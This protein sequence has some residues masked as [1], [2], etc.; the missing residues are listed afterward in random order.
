MLIQW[1]LENDKWKINYYGVQ[2]LP[3][4]H[5]PGGLQEHSIFKEVCHFSI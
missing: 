3:R 2:I 5:K 4:Q 1:K